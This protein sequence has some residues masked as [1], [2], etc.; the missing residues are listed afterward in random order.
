MNEKNNLCD[1][2]K[3]DDE[4]TYSRNDVYTFF[5]GSI[6][7]RNV[8]SNFLKII[9]IINFYVNSELSI[10]PTHINQTFLAKNLF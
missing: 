3:L 9:L 2:I 4:I 7:R 8:F 10:T 5:I 1:E 6:S